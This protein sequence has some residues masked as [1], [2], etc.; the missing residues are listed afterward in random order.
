[1]LA[2]DATTQA[3]YGNFTFYGKPIVVKPDD[4][5]IAYDIFPNAC[6]GG[7]GV[8]PYTDT[9]QYDAV[10]GVAMKD[11][12]YCMVPY[13]ETSFP[14][15]MDMA[16]RFYTYMD[17]GMLDDEDPTNSILHY[18][19]AGFYNRLWRWHSEDD[20]TLQID[21]PLY[22]MSN[23]NRI[24]WQGAQGKYNAQAH[25]GYNYNRDI[26]RNK[27]PWGVNVYDGCKPGRN[28]EM[29]RPRVVTDGN[30]GF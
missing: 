13:S 28:G 20:I 4:I 26:I 30:L 17:S 7:M 5:F 9:A 15:I 19:T 12:F 24:V 11:I 25:G 10:Q 22:A 21:Q 2:D 23:Q 1:M 27:S 14:T 16:G 29:D 6:L 3:H 8:R 18:S